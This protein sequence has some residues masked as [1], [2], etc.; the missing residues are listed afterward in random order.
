[1]LSKSSLKFGSL[2]LFLDETNIYWP[3]KHQFAFKIST[4][5]G[6]PIQVLLKSR[7]Q[8]EILELYNGKQIALEIFNKL[9][10]KIQTTTLQ[11]ALEFYL[12]YIIIFLI[13]NQLSFFFHIHVKGVMKKVMKIFLSVLIIF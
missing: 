13:L 8:Y 12:K 5:N 6:V 1:M 10:F 4:S 2:T 9:K 7:L 3:F 11:A